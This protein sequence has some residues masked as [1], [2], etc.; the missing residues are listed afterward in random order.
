MESPKK[1]LEDWVKNEWKEGILKKQVK[2]GWAL[3]EKRLKK[4]V[5][6]VLKQRAEIEQIVE[7]IIQW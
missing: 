2:K 6:H 5:A 4:W 3:I 7:Q 1:R